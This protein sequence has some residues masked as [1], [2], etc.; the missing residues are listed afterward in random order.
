MISVLLQTGWICCIKAGS[1]LLRHHTC[2]SNGCHWT[3]AL[4]QV[5]GAGFE[6]PLKEYSALSTFQQALLQMCVRARV[7]VCMCVCA[8]ALSH[9]QLFGIPWTVQITLYLKQ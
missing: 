2:S 8:C 5:K 9:A 3:A 6:G 1:V 7:C 4:R